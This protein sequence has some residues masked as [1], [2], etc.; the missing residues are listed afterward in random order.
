MADVDYNYT[1]TPVAVDRLEQEIQSSAIV[2]ALRHITTLGS[3]LTI[4]MADTLSGGDETILNGIV[5]AH[6]GVLLA[7]PDPV[8]TL[9]G[10]KDP[11]GATISR[12]KVTK[13][14]WHYEPRSLDF[15]T[16]TFASLYNKTHDTYTIAGGT[17]YADG[18]LKFYSTSAEL[19]KGGGES[20]EA[21]QARLDT[22]CVM[23]IM[24]WQPY[25][26]MDIIGGSL[27]VLN[28][29]STSTYAWVIVAPDLPA[30]YGG[31]VPFM[32]GGWNL[33][34]L[35]AKGTVS[36]DGRGVKLIAYDPVYKTNKFRLLIKHSAGEKINIQGIYDHFR[37]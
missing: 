37:A 17:D 24:D 4:T 6:T 21:F 20:A 10:P 31:N 14:G 16:S 11:D 32:A 9:S 18:S 26:D 36:F 22:D 5:T 13:A 33:S 7:I 34:F 8:V 25:Y 30:I 15:A 3:G 23:T 35:E 12:A 27:Q 28:P 2:I 1:K 29:P 19:V